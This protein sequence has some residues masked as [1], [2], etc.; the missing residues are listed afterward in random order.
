M[1]EEGS[2]CKHLVIVHGYLFE[3]SGSNVYVKNVAMSWKT[4]GHRVTVICQ[5]RNAAKISCV[6]H[7]VEGMPTENSPKPKGG[8]IRIIVPDIDSLLPVY[9]MN[10]YEG[11]TVKT[12]ENMSET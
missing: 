3:G 4:Q 9:V 11:Y 5:D 12:I 6:D 2:G 1:K 7:F 10:E 8:E